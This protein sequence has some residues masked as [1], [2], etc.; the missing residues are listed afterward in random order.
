MRPYASNVLVQ[1]GDLPIPSRDDVRRYTSQFRE[2]WRRNLDS[3]LLFIRGEPK[4][5]ETSKIRTPDASLRAI[6][7]ARGVDWRGPHSMWVVIDAAPLN[8][9]PPLGLLLAALAAARQVPAQGTR[10]RTHPRAPVESSKP[11]SSRAPVAGKTR[12]RKRL[13]RVTIIKFVFSLHH[14]SLASK[15]ASSFFQQRDLDI[16]TF[17]EFEP[18][19][20]AAAK[21]AEE[22]A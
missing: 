5:L 17:V 10:R 14:L 18:E 21:L 1:L 4:I 7:K 11:F 22:Q 3:F 20:D 6:T 13:R 8:V 12:R 2:F 15:S 9:A 19:A 16:S